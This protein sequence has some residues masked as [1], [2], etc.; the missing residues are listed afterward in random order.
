MIQTFLP[1]PYRIFPILYLWLTPPDI[2]DTWKRLRPNDILKSVYSVLYFCY[3]SLVTDR[4]NEGEGVNEELG[5]SG[6]LVTLNSTSSLKL[7]YTRNCCLSEHKDRKYHRSCLF[8]SYL[9]TTEYL[10]SP[11]DFK[12]GKVVL[13]L[14]PFSII[15]FPIV[16]EDIF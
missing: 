5:K 14:G 4:M 7:S 8:T 2:L 15:T 11:F 6:R 16:Q 9:Y 10:I 12:N 1:I 13:H 3:V